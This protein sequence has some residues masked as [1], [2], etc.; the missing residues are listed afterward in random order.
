MSYY[1]LWGCEGWECE[2]WGC[3][4]CEGWGCEECEGWGCE[5]WGCEGWGDELGWESEVLC[6]CHCWS[7]VEVSVQPSPFLWSWMRGQLG[8]QEGDGEG[9]EEEGEEGERVEW[10]R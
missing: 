4:E 1:S 10:R 6:G 3:E 9:G 7:M 5:G 2:G 8:D